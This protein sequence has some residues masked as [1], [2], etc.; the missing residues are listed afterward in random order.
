LEKKTAKTLINESYLQDTNS[1][2]HLRK[3]E[4]VPEI[5][6]GGCL[7]AMKK[8]AKQESIS[9]YK[10]MLE[11]KKEPKQFDLLWTEYSKDNLKIS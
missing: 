7:K 4:F 9:F 10:W 6:M 2:K 11:N 8:F 3:T 1:L 5:Y